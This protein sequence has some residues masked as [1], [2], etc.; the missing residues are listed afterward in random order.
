MKSLLH[1]CIYFALIFGLGA[2]SLPDTKKDIQTAQ[3]TDRI[4]NQS[5]TTKKKGFWAKV[6]E[7]AAER[8]A[9]RLRKDSIEKASNPN[10]MGREQYGNKWAFAFDNGTLDCVDGFQAIIRASNG[11]T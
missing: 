4:E 1:K 5:D 7:G 2:C 10:Y 3:K 9:E 11:K 8:K 6:K